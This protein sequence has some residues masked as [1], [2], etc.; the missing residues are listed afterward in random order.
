MRLLRISKPKSVREMK[1]YEGSIKV[2][3]I[4]VLFR[5]SMVGRGHKMAGKECRYVSILR[6]LKKSI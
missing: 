2:I 3:S 4:M 1:E 6:V 5:K